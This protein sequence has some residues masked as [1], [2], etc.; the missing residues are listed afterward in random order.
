[1]SCPGSTVQCAGNQ[2]CPDGITCPS[3]AEDF[4]SCP[5]PKSVDCLK[6]SDIVV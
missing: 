6:P 2:C 5:K 3:A 4:S 1:V